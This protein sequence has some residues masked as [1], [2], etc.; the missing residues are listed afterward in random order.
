[1]NPLYIFDIDGTLALIEHRVHMLKDKSDGQ[2]WRKFYAACDKD[3]PNVPVINTMQRLRASSDIWLFSGRSSEVRDK[4]ILW[5][6]IYCRLSS[7]YIEAYNML[8]M[9]DLG[10]C[11]PDDELKESW[12]DNMLD[13]DKERLVAVFDDRQRVVDMWRSKGVTCFQVA[14]GNF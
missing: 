14:N 3:L 6:E 5:L 8:T 7:D 13:V 12:Y 4:T 1:M 9:R 2:R 11:T 10:D